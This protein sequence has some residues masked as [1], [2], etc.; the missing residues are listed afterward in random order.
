MQCNHKQKHAIFTCVHCATIAE[1][2]RKPM[3]VVHLILKS[4]RISKILTEKAKKLK[5]KPMSACHVNLTTMLTILGQRT[6]WSH[7]CRQIAAKVRQE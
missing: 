4:G 3:K 1:C 7:Y 6:L 2:T 5:K